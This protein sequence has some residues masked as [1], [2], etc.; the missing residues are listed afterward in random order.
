MKKPSL[1]FLLPMLTAAAL[2]PQSTMADVE[3]KKDIKPIFEKRCTECHNEKMKKPKGGYVFDNVERIKTEIGPSFLI[4]PGDSGNSDLMGMVTRANKDH[5]MPPDAKDALSPKEI[6]TLKEWIDAGA[7]I[8]APA[9]AAKTGGSGL[10]PRTAA[11]AVMDWTNTEGKVIKASMVKINGDKVT[12]K[13][14]SKEYVLPL[15]SLS[16][17]SQKQALKAAGEIAVKGL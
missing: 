5:P 4:R 13:M 12:L 8:D 10:A 17:E 15:S 11:T 3:Y 1:C 7:V 16:E 2:F 6:K 14:G 9:G